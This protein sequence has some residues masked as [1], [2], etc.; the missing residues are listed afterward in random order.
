VKNIFIIAIISIIAIASVSAQEKQWS[1]EAGGG[2]VLP[3]A[4]GVSYTTY[5]PT[6][7]AYSYFTGNTTGLGNY[8]W[9]VD[10]KAGYALSTDLDLLINTSYLNGNATFTDTFYIGSRSFGDTYRANWSSLR[11][12]AGLRYTFLKIDSWSFFGGTGPLLVLPSDLVVN[13][14]DNYDSFTAT[15]TITYSPGIGAYG[16]LGAEYRANDS[17][18]ISLTLAF[19]KVSVAVT[20]EKVTDSTG[21]STTKTYTSNPTVNTSNQTASDL[22]SSTSSSKYYTYPARYVDLSDF[23]VTVGLVGHF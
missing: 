1:L 19:D 4:Q 13:I 6:T 16:E 12:A 8:G 7:P 22:S 11:F 5:S 17:F 20:K 9:E 18:G 23:G 10:G 3:F 14:S 21:A 2:Y 15:D